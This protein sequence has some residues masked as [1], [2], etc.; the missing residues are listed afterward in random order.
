MNKKTVLLVIV[1]LAIFLL[2]FML[3]RGIGG[4]NSTTTPKA[5]STEIESRVN[6]QQKQ[7]SVSFFSTNEYQNGGQVEDIKDIHIG[8]I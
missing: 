6:W 1:L 4:G 3:F 2:L 7:M 8:L 5:N